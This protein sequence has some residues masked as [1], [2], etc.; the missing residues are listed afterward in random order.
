MKFEELHTEAQVRALIAEHN[1]KSAYV[2]LDTETTSLDARKAELIDI[3]MSIPGQED[4]AAIFP[5]RFAPLLKD[6]ECLQ[7]WQNFKYDFKVL[8]RHGVDLLDKPVH[9]PLLLSHLYDENRDSNSLD[10]WVQE[11]YADD[12]KERFWSRNAN[13]QDAPGVE[14]IDYACKDIVYTGRVYRHLLAGLRSQNIPDSLV[15]HVHRLAKALFLTEVQGLKVDLPYLAKVGLELKPG[16]EAYKKSMRALVPAACESVELDTWAKKVN[17]LYSPSPRAKA[18]AKLQKPEFNWNSNDHITSLLYAKL[19]L[20]PKFNKDKNLTADDKA[21]QSLEHLHPLIADLRGYRDLQKVYTSFI[22]GTLERVD[23]GR[24]YPS[25]NING[26]VT[27]RISSSEPNL[28]QLPSKG[29]WAKVRGIYCA[30]AGHKILTCDYDQLE[31]CIAAHY[32]LDK[33]LLKIVHEGASKH[34][35]TAQG[36]GLPRSVAK[37]LNFAM[38]YQCT[39]KKVA[40]IVGCSFKE[41]QLIW[42]KYWETYA[43]ERDVIEQCNAAVD[44]GAPIKLPSGRLRRFPKSFQFEWQR[45]AAYRQ[46][47]SSLIQGTG[48]ECTHKAFY[49]TSEAMQAN[50]FGRALFEV[51]DELALMPKD[52]YVQDVT[53]MVQYIMQDAGKHYKLRVPLTASCSQP[54]ERWEK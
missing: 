37:T 13:Y 52:A 54:C 16:I 25:F 14:Q 39:P 45:Q 36:V 47:Y 34:D 2:V 1:A 3:Q 41:A 38:Q 40:E 35:I 26:T 21:L 11:L 50:A 29:E 48:A 7:V 32:S 27:G 30:E 49:E 31:V 17:K 44:A 53:D 43:G 5:G 8:S 46:A 28:Q 51:H 20:T 4:A 33:N 6:L 18:W 10:S 42:N 24:I 15:E 9:D 19:G 23:D 12:Y 22:E